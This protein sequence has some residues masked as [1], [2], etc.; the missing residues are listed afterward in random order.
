MEYMVVGAS[1]DNEGVEMCVFVPLNSGCNG[2]L[3]SHGKQ[4][5]HFVDYVLTIRKR[6][7]LLIGHRILMSCAAAFQYIHYQGG[8]ETEEAYP[9]LAKD[10]KCA[11]SPNKVVGIMM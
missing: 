6:A 7:F 8:I 9:Y 2:G 11:F 5:F 3:P 1:G 10:E 4:N